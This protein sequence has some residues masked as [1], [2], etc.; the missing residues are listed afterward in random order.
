MF[1][2]FFMFILLVHVHISYVTE[3]PKYLDF[4]FIEMYLTVK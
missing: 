2:I 4:I 3:L 1:L